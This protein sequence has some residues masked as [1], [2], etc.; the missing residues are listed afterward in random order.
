VCEVKGRLEWSKNKPK[1]RSKKEGRSGQHESKKINNAH[2]TSN[3][4]GEVVDWGERQLQK[5]R[6]RNGAK[7]EKEGREYE[8][9]GTRVG[10]L[11]NDA[12]FG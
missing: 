7:R 3:G 5:R 12:G 10:G 6:M 4:T 8:R 2:T 9:R 11:K 1:G